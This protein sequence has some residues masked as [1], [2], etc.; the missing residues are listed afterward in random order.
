MGRVASRWK[1]IK[2]SKANLVLVI[3]GISIILLSI[4]WRLLIAPALKVVATDFDLIY[5]YEGNLSRLPQT[6]TPGE[7]L[8]TKSLPCIVER[9][10]FSRLELSS[11]KYSAV[12][13]D[14]K[15]K[16]R[17]TGEEFAKAERV[18][19]LDRR[20]CETVLAW[21]SRKDEAENVNEYLRKLTKSKKNIPFRIKTEWGEEKPFKTGYYIQF[22]FDTRKKDYPFWNPTRKCAHQAKFTRK[23]SIGGL[24]VYEF[25][26]EY[27]NEPITLPTIY[28]RTASGTEL[29]AMFSNPDLDVS[30]S[31][32]V[33][34]SYTL[35]GITELLVEP[36][37]GTIVTIPKS[38]ESISL[39]AKRKDGILVASKTIS[40]FE[41]SPSRGTL[42]YACSFGK[43]EKAKIKLQFS[44]LPLGLACLG[45]ISLLVGS[46]AGIETSSKQVEH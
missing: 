41:Y 10:L 35:T 21:T 11:P 38:S 46:F 29:K 32:T 36:K 31:E 1:G 9:R 14:I 17:S 33:D 5:F 6:Y 37:S 26:V 15:I 19:F 12:E 2:K 25:R 24:E 44:Y 34:I 18:F 20:T 3:A 22:P 13:E 30:N 16:N 45:I 40:E 43:D 28:P 23:T 4:A 27:Q 39:T 8:E 7:S 42:D